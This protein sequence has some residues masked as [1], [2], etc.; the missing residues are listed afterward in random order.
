M[1]NDHNLIFDGE[2]FMS[3]EF[4]FKASQ[5]LVK[6]YKDGIG[7]K[8]LKNY[9]PYSDMSPTQVIQRFTTVENL[10]T[11]LKSRTNYLAS[12][13]TWPDV[14]E[15]LSRNI[16]L[17]D[18]YNNEIDWGSIKTLFYGQCW[19][20]S[21]YDSELLWNARCSSE[22]KNGVCIRSTFGKLVVSF[23]NGIGIEALGKENVVARCGK[24]RYCTD[25]YVKRKMHGLAESI[26]ISDGLA[27]VSSE[28]L[29][30]LMLKRI[31]FQ[32]EEEV[33]IVVDGCIFQGSPCSYVKQNAFTFNSIGLSYSIDPDYFIDEIIIDPRIPKKE[34]SSIIEILEKDLATYGWC[35]N[36]NKVNDRQSNLYE[37]KKI[38]IELPY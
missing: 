20:T 35:S 5:S 2:T 18:K 22:N 27:L 30:N 14:Y 23:L 4:G 11:M 25:D 15:G 33:R 13:L 36:G 26:K 7:V 21:S 16:I 1:L 28:M 38:E 19:T 29:E 12:V 34:V 37:Y 6:K 17:K 24:V 8:C 10:R 31:S 9:W 3:D 32:D